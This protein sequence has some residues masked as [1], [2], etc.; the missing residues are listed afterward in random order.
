[1]D[2]TVKEKLPAEPN[3]YMIDRAVRYLRDAKSIVALEDIFVC[4]VLDFLEQ[5]DVYVPAHEVMQG[6]MDKRY[7]RRY[8]M[9][10]RE[11]GV[12][13][14]EKWILSGKSIREHAVLMGEFRA[15]CIEAAK[16]DK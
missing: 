16:K 10:C 4:A 11:K 8:E 13:I 15:R 14:P 1:M 6:R 2:K 3:A 12:E 7:V 5:Q 9:F